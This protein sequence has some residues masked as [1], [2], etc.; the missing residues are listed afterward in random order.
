MFRAPRFSYALWADI[1]PD[2]SFPQRFYN[3]DAA[4]RKK[5]RERA[6][7]ALK[8]MEA[9]RP[10]RR[11][12]QPNGIGFNRKERRERNKTGPIFAPFRAFLRLMVWWPGLVAAPP[13]D[14]KEFIF[15]IPPGS[16]CRGRVDLRVVHDREQ[17]RSVVNRTALVPPRLV[18]V[19]ASAHQRPPRYREMSRHGRP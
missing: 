2:R 1:A 5:G 4:S 9:Q 11:Q 6:A 10:T 19:A 16:R 3:P 8:A 7:A 17:V 18:T 12:L 15:V 13:C 14:F